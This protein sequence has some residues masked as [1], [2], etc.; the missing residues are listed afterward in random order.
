MFGR[1]SKEVDRWLARGEVRALAPLAGR[2][3]AQLL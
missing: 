2:R 3:V 1:E